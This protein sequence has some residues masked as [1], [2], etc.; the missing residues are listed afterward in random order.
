LFS[1]KSKGI[2]EIEI[3]LGVD[4]NRCK[5]LMVL[6]LFLLFNAAVSSQVN[7]M[8]DKIYNKEKA[9]LKES[10]WL[11]LNGAGRIEESS[12]LSDVDNWI[13]Q[14]GR[15]DFLQGE[16][17]TREQMA[18]VVMESYPLPQGLMYRIFHSPRYALKD[19]KYL[20]LLP[21]I[22]PRDE[23]LTPF[24]L[25]NALSVIIEGEKP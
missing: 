11:I 18:W 1:F 15:S 13:A 5:P 24:E 14:S 9:P 2:L 22:T 25:V 7:E 6:L 4:M 23:E 10:I 19:L 20:D 16:Y 17:L 12:T 21:D 3:N 8:L